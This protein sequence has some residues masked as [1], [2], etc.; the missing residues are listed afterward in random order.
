MNRMSWPGRIG[1]NVLAYLVSILMFFPIFWLILTSFKTNSLAG[2]RHPAFIF[3]P[4]LAGYVN[5]VVDSNYLHYALNSVYA[6]VGSTLLCIVLGVPAAYSMAFRRSKRTDFTLLWMLSTKM[7]PAV[8][9]LVPI[10]LV[11][12]NLHL[13]D[14]ALGLLFI[15]AAMNLPIVVWLLYTYFRDVPGE[16]LEAAEIDG[17][18]L[19]GKIVR[20]VVPLTMPGITSTALLAI[21]LAWNEAFWAINLTNVHGATLAVFV[22]GF[23]SARGQFWANMAAAS[24]L[25]VLPILIAG[26][27]TQRQLVRGLT[28]GA[29][30]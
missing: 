22:A 6:A 20:I 21:V 10:Y 17:A 2:S 26:W 29:V 19:L 16:I 24:T 12:K 23:K 4:T 3:S 27:F 18:S 15:Y 5:A 11:Y 14:S 8:G 1:V 7:L 9:V 13:L 30:K 25:S 28:F